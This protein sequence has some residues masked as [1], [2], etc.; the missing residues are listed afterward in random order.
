M[1][2]STGG[3]WKR[4]DWSGSLKWDNPTGNR[5]HQGFWTYRQNHATAPV[6][7]PTH[8]SV[9]PNEAYSAMVARSGYV[10]IPGSTADYVELLPAD[11]RRINH[12]AVTFRNRVYDSAALTPSRRADSGISA[13][14]GRWEL[15]YDPYD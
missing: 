2:G 10:P 5:G 14:N 15:H 7:D 13:Q 1:P 8:R 12:D 3:S 9:S 6:P 4:S 11:W